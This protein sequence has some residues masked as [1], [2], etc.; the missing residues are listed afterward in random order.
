MNFDGVEFRGRA[1]A[2]EYLNRKHDSSFEVVEVNIP[3]DVE[4][5]FNFILELNG[6]L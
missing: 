4:K 1:F 6:H 3:K 2:Q 5:M